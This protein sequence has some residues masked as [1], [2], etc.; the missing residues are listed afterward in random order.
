MGWAKKRINTTVANH[1]NRNFTADFTKATVKAVHCMLLPW[2][3]N[4]EGRKGHDP[5]TV[6]I[7]CILKVGFNQIHD[8]IEAHL[9]DSE[10]IKKYYPDMPGHSVIQRGMKQLSITY[11]QKVINRVIRFLR[12]KEMNIAVGTTGFSTQNCSIWHDIKI[13]RQGKRKECL[14]LHVSVDIDT[15]VIH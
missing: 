15:G 12:R 2:E 14:K 1:V 11:I 9:K 13:E 6:A 5:Q 3:L 7:G 4:K 8:G 10:T